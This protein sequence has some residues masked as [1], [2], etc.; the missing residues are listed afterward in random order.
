MCND[1]W[2]NPDDAPRSLRDPDVL[3]RRRELLSS[4]H[5][6]TLNVYVEQLRWEDPC[7]E[8]PDFDPLDGGTMAEALFLFEKPGPRTVRSGGSGFISRNN[9]DL[10]AQATCEFMREAG[11]PRECIVIWNVVPG[12]NSTRKITAREVREGIDHLMKLL[13]LLNNLRVVVFVGRKAAR[14]HARVE[15]GFQYLHLLESAHPSPIV[16]ATRR[17]RWD[18]IPGE[19]TS[20]RLKLSCDCRGTGT[21]QIDC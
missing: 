5:M 3:Q 17:A 9:D 16:R 15:G 20:V 11:I 8:F 21:P 18:G 7:I 1:E 10:T 4:A 2:A 14:A 12:W 19:W 6:E 13:K